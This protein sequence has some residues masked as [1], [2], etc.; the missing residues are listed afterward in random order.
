M[1][2]LQTIHFSFIIPVYNRPEE[3]DELLASLSK[4]VDH[5]FEVVIV[6]DGSTIPAKK[7]IEKYKSTLNISYFFIKNSGPGLARNFGIRQAKGN[8]FIILDS[9]VIVPS[10][11]LKIVRQNLSQNY[12]DA[13]GGPD[14]AHSSFTTIQKAINF[15]MTAILT[16]GGIRGASEKAEK[17]HPRSFNMGLSK[18]I[19]KK[20]GGF[21]SMRYGEDID[22]SIR[23]MKEG[24]KTRLMPEAYVFHKRRTTLKSFFKQVSHSGTARIELY[25]KHPNSLKLVHFFPFLFTLGL[26]FSIVL[27]LTHWP[28]L[29]YIYIIYFIFLVVFAVFQYKNIKI[30][31]LSALASFVMLAGYGWGFFKALFNFKR[32]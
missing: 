32:N 22:L 18:E 17:F 26:L 20:T 19:F 1:S 30:G 27:L 24:F 11:Y 12:T 10:H 31:V 23:I 28:Y 6:E 8:Y 7:I 16:T 3:L 29:L 4:Q 21:S 15:A 9:D 5:D 14:A 2:K 25:K 13:Y